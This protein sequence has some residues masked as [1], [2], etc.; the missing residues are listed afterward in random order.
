MLLFS[1]VC[2][3]ITAA[4]LLLLFVLSFFYCW[5]LVTS[6]TTTAEVRQWWIYITHIETTKCKQTHEKAH[7]KK[8]FAFIVMVRNGFN[9]YLNWKV[10]RTFTI[11]W[12]QFARI[13]EKIEIWH[14]SNFTKFRRFSDVQKSH[15]SKEFCIY[16][17]IKV[18]ENR[19]GYNF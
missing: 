8:W 4:L 10:R 13:L 15:K 12:S 18:I 19:P 2:K 7:F 5:Y 3:F 14:V 16:I 11:L 17:I 1:D 9:L 6:Q